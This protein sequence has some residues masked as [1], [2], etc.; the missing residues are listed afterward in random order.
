M[1]SESW[2]PGHYLKKG[3]EKIQGNS[4]IEDKA[5]TP[6]PPPPQSAEDCPKVAG[7]D[8]SSDNSTSPTPFIWATEP[9]YLNVVGS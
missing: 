1:A 2:K 9:I 5:N 8:L 7:P 6:L 4:S 3:M